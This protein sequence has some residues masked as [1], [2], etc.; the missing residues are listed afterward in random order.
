MSLS[1]IADHCESVMRL[2]MEKFREH[3]E[4]C[5]LIK[6]PSSCEEINYGGK[7]VAVIVFRLVGGEQL[8]NGNL[9][10]RRRCRHIMYAVPF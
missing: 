7:C 4:H 8:E 9:M 6:R 10:D 2:A 5:V 1:I 3:V